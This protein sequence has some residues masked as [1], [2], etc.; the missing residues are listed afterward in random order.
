MGARCRFGG[1]MGCS[2]SCRAV[3]AHCEV[4]QAADTRRLPHV[5]SESTREPPHPFHTIHIDHKELP[6]SG[7]TSYK[8][9]LVVVCALTRFCIAIPTETTGAEETCRALQTHVFN[10]FSYP[11]RLISDNARGFDSNLMDEFSKFAGF[12]ATKVLANNP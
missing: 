4:C 12:R 3:V 10:L 1:G 11:V 5:H 2:S 9:L 6:V 7:S 8:Y